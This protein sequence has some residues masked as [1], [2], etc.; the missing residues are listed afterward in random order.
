M[1][2]KAGEE[3]TV[4]PYQWWIGSDD[5]MAT[6]RSPTGGQRER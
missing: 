2:S 3:G 6:C 4:D 1:A 5:A